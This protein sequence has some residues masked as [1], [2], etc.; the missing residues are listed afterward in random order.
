MVRVEGLW[1]DAREYAIAIDGNEQVIFRVEPCEMFCPVGVSVVSGDLSWDLCADAPLDAHALFARNVYV[2]CGSGRIA[3]HLAHLNDGWVLDDMRLSLPGESVKD[4][5]A[6]SFGELRGA[7]SALLHASEESGA[8][9][10]AA[11][12]SFSVGVTRWIEQ[13]VVR[14]Y[15]SEGA[16]YVR[17]YLSNP[18]L[19]NLYRLG[20]ILTSRLMPYIR[21]ANYQQRDWTEG[22]KDYDLPGD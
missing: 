6:G 14:D 19:E 7:V 15:G 21:A 22:T 4:L 13:L 9:V 17:R 12:Q 20:P 1:A 8:A 18:S 5:Y 2:D 16:R 10:R 3:A 11:P